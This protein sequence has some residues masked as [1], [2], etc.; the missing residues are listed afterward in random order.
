MRYGATPEQWRHYSTVLGLTEDLLPVVSNPTAVVSP[1]SKM[2]ALGKTP[3]RYNHE[4]HAVGL[5]EWT[6][7]RATARDIERWSA[8]PDFGIA[9]QTRR[10]RAIDVDVDDLSAS[11]GIVEALRPHLPADPLIR[12]RAGSGKLLIPFRYLDGAL[13]KHVVP[14]KGGM[15]E[16]LGDGQ[17][18][19]AEGL[20]VSGQRYEWIGE[21]MPALD[22]ED[23]T[24]LLAALPATG[25]IRIARRRKDLNGVKPLNLHDDVAEWL[26]DNWKVYD[27]EEDGRLYLACPFA[28]EHTTDSGATSCAYFPAGTGGYAEGNFVCLHA[29]C[30]G[31]DQAEFLIETGF[32]A[33]SFDDLGAHESEAFPRA[34]TSPDEGRVDTGPVEPAERTARQAVI[35][36]E[37]WPALKRDTTGILPTM[38]NLLAALGT[39]FLIQR[40]L[41]FDRFKDEMVWAPHDQPIEEAQWRLFRD[42]DYARIRRELEHRGFKPFGQD[43]LRLAALTAAEENSIDSAQAWL[44]RL[45]WDGT[46]RLERFM[47]CGLG[48]EDSPYARA[49]GRYAWTALAGRVIE[50]GCQADM[51]IISVGGQGIRKTAAIM[52]LVPD[53]D[54][55]LS[56]KLSAHDD[57]SSRKMRGK[58]VVELEELRGIN[59]TAIEEIKAWISRRA[60]EWI[61]K[62]RE[63]STRFQRRFIFFGDTNEDEFLNDPTGER[64]W[65]PG[66]CVTRPDD[67]WVATNRDQL[68]AEG[69]LLFRLDGVDWQDAE[70]LARGQHRNFKISDAWEPFVSDWLETEQLNGKPSSWRFVT[71]GD[72]LTGA[73][74]LPIHAIDLKRQA[75]MGKVLRALG[76]RAHRIRDGEKLV[77]AFVKD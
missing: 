28:D 26:V 21:D 60:E 38:T 48:W 49:V 57:D 25:P 54:F 29:H 36:Q 19:I 66:R 69:A 14:V 65:L 3:S 20:H 75:K 8:E 16:I 7:H 18:F 64:R 50:P 17:Q 74:G 31:R 6:S 42:S 22:A 51:A 10:L 71:T 46:P 12:R 59:S 41:A 44:S 11:R 52:A 39:P 23:F 53:P 34:D 4:R 55:Y 72:A 43:M 61:P 2:K 58:L 33:G 73:I 76:Y 27:V 40:H 37:R 70:R 62:W 63:F 77:S 32:V 68:W 56:A 9:V 30:T 47:S 5:P 24:A 35:A 67:V 45:R 13:Q 1:R 15:V